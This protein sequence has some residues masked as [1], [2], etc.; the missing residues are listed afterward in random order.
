M[1]LGYEISKFGRNDM[2][3]IDEIEQQ[4]G[5]SLIPFNRYIKMN[6]QDKILSS[7]ISNNTKSD[8]NSLYFANCSS[9][10]FANLN[11]DTKYLYI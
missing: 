9:L 6:T 10:Y 3:I 4:L 1:D 11:T 2:E 8:Y 5:V 7:I